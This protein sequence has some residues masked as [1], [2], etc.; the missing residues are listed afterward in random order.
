MNKLR[1]TPK[2]RFVTAATAVALTLSVAGAR[3]AAETPGLPET[4]TETGDPLTE[5][6]EPWAAVT[7]FRGNAAVKIYGPEESAFAVAFGRVMPDRTR[8]EVSA[9]LIGTVAIVTARGGDVLAYYPGDNVAIVG[10]GAEMDLSALFGPG[11]GTDFHA[12]VDGLA[13]IPSLYGAGEE[14]TAFEATTKDGG[15]G[16]ATVTWRSRSDG[17]RHQAITYRPETGELVN[18]R[19]YR[20]DEAAADATYGDWNETPPAVAPGT[21]TIKTEDTVTEIKITRFEFNVEIP[22][23]AFSTTPPEGATVMEV[24]AGFYEEP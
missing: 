14:E 11:F 16:L 10:A 1:I 17:S 12:L 7:A 3:S 8:I 22:D 21:V 20:E 5:L 6:R 2:R 4:G 19:L 15:D 23:E 9:P 13:G 24:P 18:V